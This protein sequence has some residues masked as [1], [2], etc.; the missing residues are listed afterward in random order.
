MLFYF[1][2]RFIYLFETS[3][4]NL[5]FL[6]YRINF[7]HLQDIKCNL[8]KYLS[9]SYLDVWKEIDKME[10]NLME[11]FFFSLSK[12][13]ITGISD[14]QSLKYILFLLISPKF[15]GIKT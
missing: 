5:F 8:Q 14:K 9:L 15:G 10:S 7:L 11:D 3:W 6:N 4:F 2:L 12:K 1:E 13:G